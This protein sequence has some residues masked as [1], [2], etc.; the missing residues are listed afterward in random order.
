M[1]KRKTHVRGSLHDSIEMFSKELE[2]YSDKKEVKPLKKGNQRN[3]KRCLA[4]GNLD[5]HT[6][7]SWK[8]VFKIPMK[9]ETGE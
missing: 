4:K 2:Q 1:I 7:L 9:L 3:Y 8:R 6:A 5:Y